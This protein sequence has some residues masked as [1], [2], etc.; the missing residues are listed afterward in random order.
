MTS[1]GP[2]AASTLP[3]AGR[4]TGAPGVRRRSPLAK[5][6]GTSQGMPATVT[7]GRPPQAAR[8]HATRSASGTVSARAAITSTVLAALDYGRLDQGSLG[9]PSWT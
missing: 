7:A 6:T 3:G 5:S 8:S 2:R 9:A 4:C 1:Q